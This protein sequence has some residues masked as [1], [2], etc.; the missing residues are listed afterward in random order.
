VHASLLPQARYASPGW[1]TGDG[2]NI[3]SVPDQRQAYK[4]KWVSYR[5]WLGYGEGKPESD[6]FLAFEEAREIVREVGLG[7]Y[8]EWEEWSRDCRPADIPSTHDVRGRGVE[9]DG[10]L[11]GLRQGA[12]RH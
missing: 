8:K 9:V 4:D 10:G 1:E 7:S 5:D 2:A 3:L 12:V 11:A 6:E